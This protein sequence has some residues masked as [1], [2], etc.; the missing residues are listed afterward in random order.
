MASD[1]ADQMDHDVSSLI[2]NEV[3]DAEISR[4]PSMND[5]WHTENMTHPEKAPS[6]TEVQ[7]VSPC[8]FVS[9]M[10]SVLNESLFNEK[11]NIDSREPIGN[12]GMQNTRYSVLNNHISNKRK[13][14]NHFDMVSPST[15][16]NKTRPSKGLSPV[17]D[18]GNTR[19][20][21]GLI[22]MC[23]D[24]MR[25]SFLK[26]GV[27][28]VHL[29]KKPCLDKV[30]AGTSLFLFEFEARTLWGIYRA[31]S[32][33]GIDINK[34]IFCGT[35]TASTAQVKFHSFRKC[36]PLPEK[37]FKK[38]IISNYYSPTK[39]AFELTNEQVTS[40]LNVYHQRDA[41]KSRIDRGVIPTKQSRIPYEL[42]TAD[43]FFSGTLYHTENTRINDVNGP[44]KIQRNKAVSTFYQCKE[45]LL[46]SSD[47]KQKN[48]KGLHRNLACNSQYNARSYILQHQNDASITNT[49]RNCFSMLKNQELEYVTSNVQRS[50]RIGGIDGPLLEPGNTSLYYGSVGEGILS[51][52]EFRQQFYQLD[53]FYYAGGHVYEYNEKNKNACMTTLSNRLSNTTTDYNKPE[54]LLS[55]EY[56]L[57]MLKPQPVDRSI[58]HSDVS[59]TQ[60]PHRT[61]C[62]QHNAA[63]WTSC[64]TIHSPIH[65][66]GNL[67][68]DITQP[69]TDLQ[70]WQVHKT[71][72][73]SGNSYFTE[74][75]PEKYLTSPEEKNCIQTKCRYLDSF[76][77]MG[78]ARAQKHVLALEGPSGVGKACTYAT[79]AFPEEEA[80][81]DEI[82]RRNS[83]LL[84]SEDVQNVD[85]YSSKCTSKCCEFEQEFLRSNDLI[86]PKSVL[87]NARD[88]KQK[89]NTLHGGTD[90]GLC[91]RDNCVR[92]LE[93]SSTA[94][95]DYCNGVPNACVNEVKETTA[96][97]NPNNV[98]SEFYYQEHKSLFKDGSDDEDRDDLIPTRRSVWSR[99]SVSRSALKSRPISICDEDLKSELDSGHLEQ[100]TD[101]ETWTGP[102]RDE[103]LSLD[104]DCAAILRHEVNVQF[105]RRKGGTS[106][107]HPATCEEQ[108]GNN[109]ESS[110][111]RRRRKIRR[112]L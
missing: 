105:K 46:K 42:T 103:T 109:D 2:D 36:R 18:D 66:I 23:N 30:D 86:R 83:L 5:I 12:L 65:I 107:N 4:S 47:K 102:V 55:E 52:N 94:T 25:R 91:V 28:G 111:Q 9:S 101:H 67:Y 43:K 6:K 75:L 15:D 87:L 13:S 61:G 92:V 40:L 1:T 104:E 96:T 8:N 84:Q 97:D 93:K 69:S 108:H 99:L 35:E 71:R 60:R 14:T 53:P 31:T 29:Q 89:R 77:T 98:V 73:A 38:A 76:P 27:L 45:M 82:C 51:R 74:A 56:F 32:E 19:A 34:E 39:F 50:G 24:Q 44:T 3:V 95:P 100:E 10:H 33:V 72:K 62:P 112:P 110:E 79:S 57:R 22:I 58:P 63:P 7:V 16:A 21:P 41:E 37:L 20:L 85:I 64:S 26:H 17:K 54:Q 88:C 59:T 68:T 78:K 80:W 81:R 70:G 11:G 106:S 90:G 49:Q 48:N